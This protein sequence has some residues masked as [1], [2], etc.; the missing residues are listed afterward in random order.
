MGSRFMIALFMIIVPSKANGNDVKTIYTIGY[1]YSQYFPYEDN[2][3]TDR[4][5]RFSVRA[6]RDAHILLAPSHDAD[7]PVYEIVLGAHNNTDNHIRGRCPCQ[8]APNASVRTVNLL[9]SQEFRNFWVRIHTET[10]TGS[11]K[12]YVQV[13]LGDS[14]KPY[15]DW[16]DSRPLVP[17]YL[18]FRSAL[19]TEWR[20]GF[21]DSNY[22]AGVSEDRRQ[23]IVTP[24]GFGQYFALSDVVSHTV[25]GVTLYFTVRT[26]KELQVLLSP[27][28]STLGDIYLI[29]IHENGAYIRKRLL[30]EHKASYQQTRFLNER[31]RL[32]FWI[33]LTTDGVIMLGKGGSLS[34]LVQ[35]RD[36]NSISAQYLSFAMSQNTNEEFDPTIYA[37]VQYGLGPDYSLSSQDCTPRWKESIGRLPSGAVRGG[38]FNQEE[39]Y[40]CRAKHEGETVP[41]NYIVNKDKTGGCYISYN[42][43]VL[44][45]YEYEILTGCNMKWI[46]ASLGYV[47]EG[48]IVGGFRKGKPKYYIVRVKHEKVLII[49]KLQPDERIAHVPY[50]GQ[51]LPFTNYEV[52]VQKT[53]IET[54]S[55]ITGNKVVPFLGGSADINSDRTTSISSLQNKNERYS[56][57]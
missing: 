53:K 57:V 3:S 20:Y 45:K 28:V 41:G 55:I 12:T 25:D 2:L 37:D 18:S 51:E 47:P 46:P 6:A 22:D 56:Y 30:G 39:M 42:F 9:S 38:W 21:K 14:D 31:E 15:H 26:S 43:S 49:G 4:M 24:P 7:E 40:V 48:A 23:T 35:W 34:P 11:S 13:G 32:R 16:R 36:P 17:R 33:K 5:I 8:E 54:A 44:Q 50:N 52:L 27:L 1:S 10:T 29:G 19:R